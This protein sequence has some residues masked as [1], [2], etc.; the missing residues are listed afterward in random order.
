MKNY[1][2]F[3]KSPKNGQRLYSSTEVASDFGVSANLLNK[4]LVKEGILIPSKK[5]YQYYEL[6][7]SS[8]GE[9]CHYNLSHK[10]DSKSS[11]RTTNV[12][13]KFS[14][15]GKETIEKLLVNK[16][17]LY[18]HGSAHP[19]DVE[20]FFPE[21][22]FALAIR[23]AGTKYNPKS[24]AKPMIYLS[25]RTNRDPDEQFSKRYMFISDEDAALLRNK[26]KKYEKQ[27]GYNTMGYRVPLDKSEI[28]R[29][30]VQWATNFYN[31]IALQAGQAR[32][33]TIDNFDRG[34]I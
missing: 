20:K 30:I 3:K 9:E 14:S 5:Q 11:D 26:I 1:D 24:G 29:S 25:Y 12:T 31:S 15:Y 34:L 19:D 27:T 16:Y 8:L 7:D 17:R 6:A 4:V 33:L 13:I 32:R 10:Y 23:K 22:K 18:L 28:A 21:G 2:L